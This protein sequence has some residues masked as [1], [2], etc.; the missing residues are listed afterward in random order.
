MKTVLLASAA[1]FALTGA[2]FAGVAHPGKVSH[3]VPHH[4]VHGLPPGSVTLYDQNDNDNGVGIVSDDFDSAFNSYDDQIADDFKVPKGT[5]WKVK[6]VDVSGAYFN[7]SGPTDGI[8]IFVYKN[9]KGI[10]GG[11][12]AE[13]DSLPPTS[14]NF[15]TFTIKIPKSCPIKLGKG[16]Y[17]LSVQSQQN[18]S[19][20]RG[21]WG[22]NT[23]NTQRGGPAMFRSNGGFGCTQWDTLANCIG[24][25][26]QG[27][28]VAFAIIGVKS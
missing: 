7:G 12:V 3:S 20:G 2:A 27:P 10:P 15:G 6:E 14:D 21:E 22:W 26:G 18:F 16:K 23:N 28:D 25:Y 8:N 4:Y 9:V 19:A 24:S 11:T 1:M 17:F 13:C 5:T